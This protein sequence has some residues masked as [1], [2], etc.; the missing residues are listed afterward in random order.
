MTT[1]NPKTKIET[2]DITLEILEDALF[3]TEAAKYNEWGHAHFKQY[4]DAMKH[5]TWAI[6]HVEVCADYEAAAKEYRIAQ[7]ILAGIEG[8]DE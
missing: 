3:N 2:A 8:V 5:L 1:Q 6:D 4:S 7:E